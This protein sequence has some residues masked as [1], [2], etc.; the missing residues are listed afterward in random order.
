MSLDLNGEITKTQFN[1]LTVD[2]GILFN[3]DGARFTSPFRQIAAQSQEVEDHFLADV[4][5]SP[6][7]KVIRSILQSVFGDPDIDFN[8]TQP[9]SWE[10]WALHNKGVLYDNTGDP[11]LRPIEPFEI[12]A[13]IIVEAQDSPAK[14][15]ELKKLGID[16]LDGISPDEF[17]I[18]T[19][20]LLAEV[21]TL[22]AALRE[23]PARLA[24]FN[25]LFGANIQATGDLNGRVT[26]F[27][28][29]IVGTPD[30]PNTDADEAYDQDDFFEFLSVAGG[31]WNELQLKLSSPVFGSRYSEFIT[32]LQNK[33]KDIDPSLPGGVN[34]GDGLTPQEVGIL[35]A[36]SLGLFYDRDILTGIVSKRTNV[37]IRD[38]ILGLVDPALDRFKNAFATLDDAR[39]V[40]VV[41]ILKGLYP[42]VTGP[43]AHSG[44]TGLSIQ[45][46][47]LVVD[48]TSE[49]V[50]ASSS[51]GILYDQATE[52]VTATVTE[53]GQN[54]S[55]AFQSAAGE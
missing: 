30:D 51:A 33:T 12:L 25:S 18:L 10:S 11:L 2:G 54:I 45:N 8:D 55:L 42:A 21:K 39:Q 26:A 24:S 13:K 19:Q 27:L 22:L 17:A 7:Q 41:N 32:A 1:L 49:L 53:S 47:Q 50:F 48:K 5:N 40:A 23:V 14:R 35:A 44:F 20:P 6:N 37:Q 16:V 31:F 52:P 34:L 46:R 28:F 4:S 38:Y 36:P 43:N 9:S 3:R 29:S 15:D